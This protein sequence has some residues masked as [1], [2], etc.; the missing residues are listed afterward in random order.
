MRK[1]GYL[2]VEG[3]HDVEFCYRLLSVAGLSRVRF[4]KDL[5]KDLEELVPRSFPHGGDLQKR[6]PVPLFLQNEQCAIA[7]HSAVGDSRLVATLEETLATLDASAFTGLGIM[8]DSDS[9]KSASE[10]YATL[11]QSVQ[12]E[13]G[14][15][16][17]EKAGTVS[18][19]PT[20]LGAFVLPDNLNK[21]TLEDLLLES[22]ALQYPAL[23]SAAAGYVDAARNTGLIPAGHQDD[24]RKPAGRN[25]AVIGAMASLF[26]PGKAV[27]TSIQDNDWLRGA[28]L[29]LPSIL[30][31]QQFLAELFELV[32]LNDAQ[33]QPQDAA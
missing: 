26:K 25:K 19:G 10:R 1:L 4:L 24:I 13:L 22:A 21:G 3:P 17:P 12:Q 6:V 23:L 15:R 16:M 28:A 30:A 27:Q 33:V 9:D 18:A 29:S 32:P 11:H 2:V 5:D 8:L 7:I 31:V 14:L 20:R